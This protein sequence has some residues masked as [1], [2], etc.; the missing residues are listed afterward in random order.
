MVTVQRSV[1]LVPAGIPV[2]VDEGE[3]GVVIVAVPLTTLQRPV[4]VVGVVPA[5]VKDP[6]LH[7]SCPLPASAVVA[8][9]S[10]VST[11]SSV[12]EQVPLVIVQRSVALV[13]AGTPVTPEVAEE[14]VVMVAVPLTT[15]QVPVPTLAVLPASVKDPL[16][17]CV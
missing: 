3:D 16:L 10:L 12:E 5:S 2:I 11:T 7:C 17:H 14:G 1:A 4:P 15:L 8:C 13:P 9:A 6:L